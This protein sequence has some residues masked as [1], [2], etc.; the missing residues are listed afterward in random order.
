MPTRATLLR[1]E[2]II[3][4]QNI[5]EKIPFFRGLSPHQARQL[6][7]IGR[8]KKFLKG[9]ALCQDGDNS[10]VM[11]VLLSGELVV[12]DENVELT[13]L[14]PLDI[15]GEM[16]LVT[17]LPRCATIE[18]SEDATLMVIGRIEFEAL[19]K[20]DVKMAAQIY[21]NMLD[22][23]CRKLRDNNVQLV[24]S[25]SKASRQIVASAI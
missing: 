14:T 3:V 23:L 21:K 15:V 16:G 11:Y 19:L 22:S 5:T 4:E 8:V 25:R 2:Q 10:T 17:G 1:I 12:K 9:Q 13:R 6:L 18:V 24:R 20:T 7:R